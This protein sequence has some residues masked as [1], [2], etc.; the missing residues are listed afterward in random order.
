L[1]IFQDEFLNGG[2]AAVIRKRAHGLTEW[3]REVKRN[4]K[5]FSGGN[6]NGNG[7]KPI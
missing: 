2:L 4:Q 3:R 6:K 1:K 7:L 5:V